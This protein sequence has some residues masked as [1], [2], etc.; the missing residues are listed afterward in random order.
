MTAPTVVEKPGILFRV[1][2]WACAVALASA[3]GTLAGMGVNTIV[4]KFGV[5]TSDPRY[6]AIGLVVPVLLYGCYDVATGPLFRGL[7]VVDDGG[8]DS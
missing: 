7:Y 6:F 4:A 2:F 1:T 8:D 3:F 5:P